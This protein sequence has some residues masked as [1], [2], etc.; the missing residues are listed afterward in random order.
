MEN[1]THGL[2]IEVWQAL[3]I[4]LNLFFILTTAILWHR[5]WKSNRPTVSFELHLMTKNPHLSERDLRIA[6]LIAEGKSNLTIAEELYI[7]TDSVKKS[8]YRL[9]KKLDI[10]DGISLEAYLSHVLVHHPSTQKT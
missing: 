5:R 7:A 9:K 2:G 8:K 4:V 3:S 6:V 10:P 1:F